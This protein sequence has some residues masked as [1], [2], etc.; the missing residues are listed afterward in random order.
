MKAGTSGF[1]AEQGR[2]MLL[3]AEAAIAIVQRVLPIFLED[4][5]NTLAGERLAAVLRA[6]AGEESI[7]QAQVD[8]LHGLTHLVA[9]LAKLASEEV[10]G[11]RNFCPC[12]RL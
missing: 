1:T 7:G 6:I 2:E 5:G 8:Q 9:S 3:E 10:N 12:G 11:T 4:P